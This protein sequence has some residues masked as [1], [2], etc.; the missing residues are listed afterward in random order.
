MKFHHSRN[1][2]E[3]LE[4]MRNGPHQWLCSCDVGGLLVSE[5]TQAGDR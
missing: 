5:L 4:S 2:D 3:R 1:N